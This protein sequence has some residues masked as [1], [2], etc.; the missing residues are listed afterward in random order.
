[1]KLTEAKEIAEGLVEEMRPHCERVEVAGSIRRGKAQVK[2]LEIV[3][4]P[5]WTEIPD[6]YDLLGERTLR[7]NELLPVGLGEPH[8]VG[9]AGHEGEDHLAHQAGGQILAGHRRGPR[10]RHPA[11]PVPHRPRELR[12]HLPHPH[13]RPSLLPGGRDPRE[14]DREALLGRLPAR[15][16]PRLRTPEEDDVWRELG[17]QPVAP[18]ARTGAE[19]VKRLVTP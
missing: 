8:L 15:R 1:M 14:G 3:A 17:F 12:D 2:D 7:Q 4:V 9:E 13:R 19:A 6:P 18:E 11:R 16:G 5:R 10:G